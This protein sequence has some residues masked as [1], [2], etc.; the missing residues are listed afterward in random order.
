METAHGYAGV[1]VQPQD[2]EDTTHGASNLL[3]CSIAMTVAGMALPLEQ[4]RHHC[5]NQVPG[6]PGSVRCFLL[7]AALSVSLV[8]P[9]CAKLCG[10]TGTREGAWGLVFRC[11]TANRMQIHNAASGRVGVSGSRKQYGQPTGTCLRVS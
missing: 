6:Y 9:G 1:T 10:N 3:L 4:Y 8:L 11:S 5:M 2:G 7:M